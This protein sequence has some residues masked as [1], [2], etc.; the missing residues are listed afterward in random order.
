METG[1]V[2][3]GVGR[4]VVRAGCVAL[5]LAACTAPGSEGGEASVEAV[6]ASVEHPHP[7][8]AASEIHAGPRG[9]PEDRPLHADPQDQWRAVCRASVAHDGVDRPHLL[10]PTGDA[11]AFDHLEAYDP[12]G[13][14]LL[15]VHD[16]R[17]QLLDASDGQA[18]DLGSVHQTTRGDVRDGQL[19]Y[20]RRGSGP[21]ILVL[22][23]LD[24]D[25]RHEL[26]SPLPVLHAVALER[27][28]RS[29]WLTGSEALTPAEREAEAAEDE[30]YAGHHDCTR[31]PACAGFDA[32]PRR[33][34]A[35]LQLDQP[36]TFIDLDQVPRHPRVLGAS[37]V[38]DGEAGV[39]RVFADRRELIAPGCRLVPEPDARDDD[40]DD[41]LLLR[42]DGDHDGAARYARWHDG[43]LEPLGPTPR[44]HLSVGERAAVDGRALG[45]DPDRGR[46]HRR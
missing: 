4:A 6:S 16:G 15:L 31:A 21:P 43:E 24:R 33:T 5:G 27:G 34:L 17:R 13:R 40:D 42:C 9:A 45:P 7:P 2:T 37:V 41:A 26:A 22:H 20:A 19:A 35:W 14:W 10:L 30:H 23:D 28:G 18:R 39:E 3:S 1:R 38:I 11:L 46:A 12:S 8:I 44:L 29:V 25:E 36:R 32:L